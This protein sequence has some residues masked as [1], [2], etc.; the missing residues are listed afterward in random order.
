[1]LYKGLRAENTALRRA[2]DPA[3]KPVAQGPQGSHARQRDT[4]NESQDMKRL[5]NDGAQET[6]VLTVVYEDQF[7][8]GKI[9]GHALRLLVSQVGTPKVLLHDPIPSQSP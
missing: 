3:E 6:S 1:M 7:T 5:V 2:A 9:Y 8:T 4:A